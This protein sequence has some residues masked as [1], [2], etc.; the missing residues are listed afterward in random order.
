MG[1]GRGGGSR[2]KN[3]RIEKFNS[4]LSQYMQLFNINARC[5][6]QKKQTV[7]PRFGVRGRSY[8]LKGDNTDRYMGKL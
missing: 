4:Y 3:E 2:D 7:K 8:G 1:G 5:M 6:H